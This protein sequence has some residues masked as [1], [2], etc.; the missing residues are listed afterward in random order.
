MQTNT[1][2]E[3]LETKQ[4]F[5]K[6]VREFEQKEKQEIESSGGVDVGQKSSDTANT[7]L[8]IPSIKERFNI[9]DRFKRKNKK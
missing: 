6:E 3:T 7:T 2:I 8:T 1:K 4:D 9:F 5:F